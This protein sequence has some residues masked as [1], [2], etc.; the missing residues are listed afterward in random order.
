[1]P[2]GL[3][4]RE[5][6][7]VTAIYLFT[8][9]ICIYFLSISNFYVVGQHIQRYQVAKSIVEKWEL[10]IPESAYSIR[11]MDGKAYS[12]YG[13]GWPI[14]AIPFYTVGKFVGGHPEDLL[15][16]LNPLVGAATVTLIFL[17]S[18]ALGYSKRPSLV[19]SMFY[20]FGTFAGP[21]AKHP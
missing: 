3:S 17:F 13:L 1:M 12:L 7:R 16:L 20:G 14:L 18:V 10:S 4:E 5:I 21:L 9:V 6:V 8:F 11:G 19:V 2:K 15:L